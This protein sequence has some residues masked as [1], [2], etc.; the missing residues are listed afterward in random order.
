MNERFLMP[1]GTG[2][3]L[4]YGKTFPESDPHCESG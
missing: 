2:E 4:P 3:T 1:K